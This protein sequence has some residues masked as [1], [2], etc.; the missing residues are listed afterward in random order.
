MKHRMNRERRSRPNRRS[1]QNGAAKQIA[2]APPAAVQP[3]G[4]DRRLWLVLLLCLVGSTAV[5]FVVFKY[6]I[7][8]SIPRELVG[9]WQVTGGGLQ[10]ATLEFRPDGT[11]VAVMYKHGK[12][13]VTNSSVQVE[14][15]KMFLTTRDESTGKEETVTQ[16]IVELT[17]DELVIRDEDQ[18]TYH[19]RRVRD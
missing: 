8:P 7:E 17:A 9:T 6:V 15:Q 3:T 16:T 12:K 5:S 10:G 13:A 11:S 4:R 18:I 2:T 1:S 19:M 14:G